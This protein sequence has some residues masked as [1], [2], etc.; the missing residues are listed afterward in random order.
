MATI[1]DFVDLSQLKGVKLVNMNIQRLL[2]KIDQL[3]VVLR[4]SK[5]HY[6]DPI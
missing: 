2:K 1:S 6:G 5:L 3:R 4:N